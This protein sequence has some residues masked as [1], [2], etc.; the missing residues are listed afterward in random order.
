MSNP[1]FRKNTLL[2]GWGCAFSSV[3]GCLS[4]PSKQLILNILWFAAMMIWKNNNIRIITSISKGIYKCH[5]MSMNYNILL[6]IYCL[7]VIILVITVSY[8]RLEVTI[9]NNQLISKLNLSMKWSEMFDFQMTLIVY[10][11]MQRM[12]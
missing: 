12:N 7:I 3:T 11:M 9:N 5:L 2:P 1:S 8:Y 10:Q 4:M 6:F